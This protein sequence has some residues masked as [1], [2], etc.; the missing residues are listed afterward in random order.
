[1]PAV[2][3]EEG[4]DVTAEQ[5]ESVAR[6]CQELAEENAHLRREVLA[7][8]AKEQANDQ[9]LAAALREIHRLR[10]AARA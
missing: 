2:L 3:T 1:M 5:I 10:E 9:A 7:L 6:C 8:R 4:G